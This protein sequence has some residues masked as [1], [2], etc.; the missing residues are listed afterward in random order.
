MPAVCCL[1]FGVC[2]VRCL[3]CVELYVLRV[4]CCLVRFACLLM[5]A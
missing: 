5:C 3:L 2:G 4:V 1:R